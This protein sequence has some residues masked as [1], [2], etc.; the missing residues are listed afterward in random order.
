V[1]LR[2]E[3]TIDWS[4]LPVLDP[5]KKLGIGGICMKTR[6]Y[7]N[8]GK[9]VSEIGFGAW[10][11]GN[12]DWGSN[13]S[14]KEA[15]MLVNEAFDQGVNF[16]DTSP[17]YGMGISEEIL[18]KALKGK[19]DKVVIN[20]KF[21]H[22]DGVSNFSAD[23]IVK[24][25]DNSCR[26]LQTDYLDSV[27]MHNPPFEML[28]GNSPQYE[29]FE[30]LKTAGRIGD[31]G[32]SVDTGD[33]MREVL[34]TTNS[35]I[36]E[37]LFNIFFQEPA[38][39]FKMA[40]DKNIGLIIKVPLDSGWLSGKYNSKSKFNDVRDRWS[41]KQILQR[42]KLLDKISFITNENTSMVQAALRFILSFNEVSTVIPGIKNTQQLYENISACLLE[43]PEEHVKK[44]KEFWSSDIKDNILEW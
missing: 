5:H 29:V 32:A 31:Y 30:K 44:L 39:V 12:A 19:R 18:G 16:F 38:C 42:S 41:E 37:V 40:A 23:F 6:Q 43:M 15:I 22:S 3:E 8:T 14:E 26:R 7:G 20:T 28:N 9:L 11:L 21:G 13:L 35:G 25:L 34:S 17:G 2:L 10:Q 36:I 4:I 24:S 33:E 1:F 27:L